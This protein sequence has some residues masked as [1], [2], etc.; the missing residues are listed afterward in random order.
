MKISQDYLKKLKTGKFV[1]GFETG[2][3]KKFK[4]EQ[5]AFA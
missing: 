2:T 3:L 4:I 5:L 1:L